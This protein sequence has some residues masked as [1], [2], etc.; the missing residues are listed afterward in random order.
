MDHVDNLTETLMNTNQVLSSH[1]FL[2]VLHLSLVLY[3]S[4]YNQYSERGGILFKQQPRTF[5]P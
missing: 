2:D 1:V 4:R 5:L 3:D